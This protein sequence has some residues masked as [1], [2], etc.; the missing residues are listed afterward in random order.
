MH[1]FQL[2]DPQ[3]DRIRDRLVLDARLGR[4]PLTLIETILLVDCRERAAL[5]ADTRREWIGN[6]HQALL[7]KDCGAVRDETVALHLADTKTT[8]SRTTLARLAG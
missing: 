4:T 7:R 1:G 5:G 2:L 3:L 8:V 6:I